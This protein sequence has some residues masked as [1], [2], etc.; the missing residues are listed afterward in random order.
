MTPR[1]HFQKL[2]SRDTLASEAESFAGLL[3]TLRAEIPAPAAFATFDIGVAELLTGGRFADLR[4][5]GQVLQTDH[6]LVGF[7]L[8]LG[9]LRSYRLLSAFL[10]FLHF[11]AFLGLRGL[12]SGL[13]GRLAAIVVVLVLFVFVV[14]RRAER[15]A[16]CGGCRECEQTVHSDFSDSGQ[17]L[18]L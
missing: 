6:V 11:L 4:L 13:T 9:G 14:G 8:F 3:Q 1:S 10:Y 5:L 12:L 17:V 18:T 2:D 7:R 16:V 15:E